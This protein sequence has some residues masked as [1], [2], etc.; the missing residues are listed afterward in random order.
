MLSQVQFGLGLFGGPKGTYGK[1]AVGPVT[2]RL[3]LKQSRER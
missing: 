3:D 1:Y 2:T